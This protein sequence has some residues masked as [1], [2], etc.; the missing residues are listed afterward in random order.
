MHFRNLV[1]IML[2]VTM[3]ASQHMRY[4]PSLPLINTPI[5][6]FRI[7]ER[8]IHRSLEVENIE[9][10]IRLI[11]FDQSQTVQG[12]TNF[13][14]I[15]ELK[16]EE[17]A[18][19]KSYIGYQATYR[20]NQYYITKMA[21]S[22]DIIDLQKLLD[23][24]A[25]DVY[26]GVFCPNFKVDFNSWDWAKFDEARARASSQQVTTQT[27]ITTTQNTS[28]TNSKSESSQLNDPTRLLYFPP[29]VD[30]S[31][32]TFQTSKTS[33]SANASAESNQNSRSVTSSSN[34]IAAANSQQTQS[35]SHFSSE[36]LSDQIAKLME[37][38]KSLSPHDNE[39]RNKINVMINQLMQANS[40]QTINVNHINS[41]P[42]VSNNQLSAS[43]STLINNGNNSN[44]AGSLLNS[45][46]T[47]SNFNGNANSIGG[48]NSNNSFNTN[49]F[50]SRSN[51]ISSDRDSASSA[52]SLLSSNQNFA[53]ISN[54][55]SDSSSEANS[56]SISAAIGNLSPAS[57][58]NSNANTGG[59]FRFS[60]ESAGGQ[61]SSGAQ[62]NSEFL[63]MLG[64]AG[65]NGK[66]VG[67]SSND[68][69]V[70]ELLLQLI[71]KQSAGG[72]GNMSLVQLQ[73]LPLNKQLQDQLSA[74]IQQQGK[75]GLFANLNGAGLTSSTSQA[76]QSRDDQNRKSGLVRP[77]QF[78]VSKQFGTTS[79]KPETIEI[80]SSVNSGGTH[81][82]NRFESTTLFGNV[83]F[84]PF[85]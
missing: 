26:E 68:S 49:N 62:N 46:N 75:S 20:N 11:K 80:N 8:L 58:F 66:S 51:S 35:S 60:L 72:A 42:A 53:N 4:C 57:S 77:T 56:Q 39:N 74:L 34:T 61:Q 7:Y 21:L 45:F 2:L 50:S 43:S 9:A 85:R 44:S 36:S 28:Q 78:L 65:Q 17:S 24:S 83:N 23:L 19:A 25:I 16:N 81:I 47:A 29:G 13:K 82:G 3:A 54:N 6:I 15:F 14:F 1:T 31:S 33:N 76:S 55:F 73:N 18:I 70:R 22:A 67:S 64:S 30:P 71:N 48:I 40:Q 10:S 12:V 59:E 37:M 32:M 38:M 79:I 63:K 27:V 69:A 5:N 84:K 41:A 52:Q